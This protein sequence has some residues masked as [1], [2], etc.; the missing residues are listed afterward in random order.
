MKR[1][2]LNDGNCPP[3][4]TSQIGDGKGGLD[5]I[6]VGMSKSIEIEIPTC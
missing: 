6:K 2:S 5:L 3:R 1:S 4:E